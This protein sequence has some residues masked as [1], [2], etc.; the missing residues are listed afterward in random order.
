M[1]LFAGP[2]QVGQSVTYQI[3]GALST[4]AAPRVSKLVLTWTAPTRLYA[5]LDGSGPSAVVSITR[6][7][8]GML[9]VS[10]SSADA[11]AVAPLLNQLNFPGTLAARLNGS[12]HAQTTLSIVSLAAAPTGTSSPAAQQTPGPVTVPVNLDLVYNPATSSAT[13]IADGN[14]TNRNGPPDSG[15]GRR[16]GGMGGGMGG[17]WMGGGGRS[18]DSDQSGDGS[19]VQAPPVGF[20]LTALFD[21]SGSLQHATFREYFASKTKGAQAIE[22]TFT[23]DRI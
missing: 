6:A 5:R 7:G 8:D 21:L 2:A 16:G 19:N 10:S 18:R 15:F 1:L 13:L 9:S 4:Q 20:A 17:G 12:D 22:E 11:A 23:I 3:T 14:S